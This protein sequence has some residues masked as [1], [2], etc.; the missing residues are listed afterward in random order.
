MPT[1]YCIKCPS[2]FYLQLHEMLGAPPNVTLEECCYL[3]NGFTAIAKDF[4]EKEIVKDFRNI[5]Y[6]MAKCFQHHLEQKGQLQNCTF[7]G[8]SPLNQ[9]K[10][11]FLWVS[12]DGSQ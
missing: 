2:Q 7:S 10:W 12:S 11:S 6:S 8:S 1:K 5:F 4:S 9:V 3:I